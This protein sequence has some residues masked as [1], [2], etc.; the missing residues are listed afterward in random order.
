MELRNLQIYNIAIELGESVWQ[1]VEKWEYYYKTSLGNQL[2][3]SADSVA[4]NISEGFGRYHFKDKKNFGY[5]ARG[6]LYE[7]STWLEK[8]KNRNL[9]GED[10]FDDLNRKIKELGVKL[11]NYISVIGRNATTE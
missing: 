2:V 1:I 9:I 8:A 10:I 7:T 6:S 5:Y 3:R 4:A 11:N